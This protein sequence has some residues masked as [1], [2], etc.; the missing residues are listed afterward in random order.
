VSDCQ[1]MKAILLVY[2]ENGVTASEGV[3]SASGLRVLHRALVGQLREGIRFV[4]E[5][6]MG[7]AVYC[8]GDDRRI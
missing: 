3:A 5:V 8:V 1:G 6:L 2:W 7:R 4:N